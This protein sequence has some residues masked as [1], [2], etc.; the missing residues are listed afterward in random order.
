MA[1]YPIKC[2]RC[3]HIMDNSTV[4]FDTAN[5]VVAMADVLT[6]RN[7]DK[8]VESFEQTQKQENKKESP[9]KS[10]SIWDDEDDDN[11][12]D[13]GF[14]EEETSQEL[15]KFMTYA[16]IQKYCSDNSIDEPMPMYQSVS[17]SP[18]FASFR[19][20]DLGLL[21]GVNFKK[22]KGG[23]AYIARRRFCPACKCELPA[24]SGAMPTYNLTIMGTS[25]SGK[26]VF[27]CAL[28]RLLAVG[29]CTLPYNSELTCVS[30]NRANNDLVQRSNVLFEEGV[31]PGTTQIFLTE[32]LVIQMTY[33]IQK[34]TKKC[35][36]ALSDMRG[37]DLAATGGEN[38][39]ARSKFFS[40]AD[41]FMILISPLNIPNIVNK[42]PQN[43]G[44]TG[45]AA[46]HQALMSNINEYI[47]PSFTDGEIKAP[48]AIAMSKCDILM[49]FV[50]YLGISHS[51]AVVAADPPIAYTGTYFRNQDRG[52]RE[53]V[54]EDF[55][56]YNYLQSIFRRCY[57]SSF[58][59]L[60]INADIVEDDGVQKVKNPNYI[61]PIRV[62]DPIVY[63][64]IE[65]GFLPAF[66]NMEV[67]GPENQQRNVDILNRWVNDR[68]AKNS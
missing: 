44:E 10:V 23:Q 3:A 53:I 38:L 50:D 36:V 9:K 37:E 14:E 15:Q 26:T 32:P 5:A 66:Y 39:I 54:K 31:L 18:D 61:K 16:Q 2:T 17:V 43:K 34:Y 19:S 68:T 56:L 7:D 20:D 30:A 65:L 4:L 29:R 40:S 6:G 60:G 25:A 24:Q 45:N 63:I 13:S 42:I 58:S 55:T 62:V 64:L 47:L 8:P 22:Q 67:G 28:N 41:A 27:L 11:S 57:F 1:H 49:N 46:V 33:R 21:T 59:S 52:T 12:F 48:C 51:N 35:L